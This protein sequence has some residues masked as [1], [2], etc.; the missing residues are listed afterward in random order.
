ME[1]LGILGGMG[2]LATCIF[3]EKIIN[4]TLA[5]SDQEHINTLISSNTSIPDRTDIILN[6][7]DKNLIVNSVKKDLEL[8]EM[9][10]VQKIAIPCNTFHYFYD[11][12]DKLTSIDIINMAEETI[13]KIYY[14]NKKN[15]VILGTK[16][17]L[18]GKIYDRY[19]NN[20]NLN[21]K[22]L[23]NEDKNKLMKIIYNIKSTNSRISKDLNNIIRNLLEK[24]IDYVILAC[25]ELS[26]VILDEDLKEYTVDSLEILA[27]KS[28]LEMGYKLNK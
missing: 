5:N 8:F 28:I 7:L 21:I 6:K 16:G 26:C 10:N 19:A 14:T 15:I 22:E 25:T 3:Y 12:I 1:K 18:D 27:K 17:T 9:A 11:D 24:D 13:K 4:N 23:N 2:P 20:Y